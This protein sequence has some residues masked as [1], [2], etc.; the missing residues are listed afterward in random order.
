MPDRIAEL[1]ANGISASPMARLIDFDMDPGVCRPYV[2]NGRTYMSVYDREK[3][4]QREVPIVNTT[5][6]L[7]KETWM[8]FDDVM[9]RVAKP[10]LSVWADLVSTGNGLT[11]P[12]G[13]GTPV[14]QYQAMSDISAATT[15]MDGLR[16]SRHD[17]PMY[18]LHNFPLPIAH[19]DFCFTAREIAASNKNGTTLDTTMIELATEKVAEEIENRVLGLTDVLSFGGGSLYGYT[20]F[21]QRNTKVITSP[22]A[23][24]WTPNTAVDEVLDMIALA[25][26]DNYNGPYNLYMGKSWMRYLNADYSAAKGNDTLRTRLSQIEGINGPK[27]VDYLTGYDII[28]VQ[29]SGFVARPVVG[30]NMTTLQWEE[31]GG[32]ELWFKVMAIMAVQLRTDQNGNCGIVHGAP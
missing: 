28:L 7:P 22:T 14:I 13:M 21:P 26:A 11:V 32:M 16:E 12:N 20:N 19:K 8:M 5:Y 25:Q 2:R 30:M 27:Q 1:V 10:R 9:V 24:G 29:R 3:R 31:K 6:T 17:R 23:A 15:S 4:K 18:D